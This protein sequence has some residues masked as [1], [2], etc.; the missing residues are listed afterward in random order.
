MKPLV[1]QFTKLT[2]FLSELEIEIKSGLFKNSS[3]DHPDPEAKEIIHPDSKDYSFE[4]RLGILFNGE[5]LE[6]YEEIERELFDEFRQEVENNISNELISPEDLN[7][8]LNDLAN[9][10]S[11]IEESFVID[12]KPKFRSKWAVHMRTDISTDYLNSE[13]YDVH[14]QDEISA[15]LKEQQWWLRYALNN[16]HN[17]A[18]NLALK[19]DKKVQGEFE[20]IKWNGN[21]N[22]LVDIFYRLSQEEKTK[23][24]FYIESQVNN[25]VDFIHSSFLNKQGSTISKSTIETILKP[26]RTDK[27]PSTDKQIDLQS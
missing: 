8:Y 14:F 22:Q 6:T 23:D 20:K 17:S 1:E 27:R 24:K 11:K 4:N 18:K 12:S 7:N 25:L 21:A 13:H 9:T 10:L 3:P 5:C 2:L 16:L 19:L 15:M 26:S